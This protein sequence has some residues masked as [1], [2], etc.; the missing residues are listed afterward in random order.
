[1]VE[2]SKGCSLLTT[3]WLT[4]I[5]LIALA[6]AAIGFRLRVPGGVNSQDLGWMSARWLAEQRASQRN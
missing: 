5:G 2:A 3:M 6:A 1:M 4:I